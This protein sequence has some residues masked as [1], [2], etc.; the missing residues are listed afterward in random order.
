MDPCVNI[1]IP[2]YN[3]IEYTL[4]CIA[5]IKR[6]SYSN[7]RIIVCDDGSTDG[8]AEILAANYPEV[9]VLKGTGSLW[10]T[11]ATNMCVKEALKSGNENDFIYT[12]NNDTE[13]FTD[14]L[15]TAV[16]LA[17]DNPMNIVGSVNV[18]FEDPSKIEPS[19]FKRTNRLLFKKM[20]VR[21][22]KLG[23][24][25]PDN[26]E[27]LE[28]DAFSGKGVLIPFSAFRQAGLYNAELLPHYHADTEFTLRTRKYGYKL[29]YSYRSKVMSH[30][31]LT[32]SGTMNKSF[33]EFTRSFNNIKSAIHYESVLNFSK[34]A[35][36]K[37]YRPYLYW[38][39][40]RIFLGYF[41]R[42]FRQS[43]NNN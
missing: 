24:R 16:N 22:H 4:K 2:V 19:A 10:W 40:V 8:S 15:E 11:G 14:T 23:D 42:F 20:P 43:Y 31:Y 30:Q 37:G 33:R 36:G 29:L 32:G 5:S 27:F 21:I 12:L 39:L 1:C 35:Y 18:F 26:K 9:T 3:R 25:I 17:L 13:L 7:C 28:V 41:R 34:L 6:Q 38:Q